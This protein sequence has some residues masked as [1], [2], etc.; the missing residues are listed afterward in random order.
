MKDIKD[1][2]LE[3]ND[4]DKQMAALFEKRMLLCQEIAAYK[5]ANGLNIFDAKREEEVIAK[6]L[7]L[8]QNESVKSY[9]VNFIRSVMNESKKYQSLIF[10]G[11]RVAYSGVPGAFAYIAAQKMYPNSNYV[12]YPDFESA[13]KACENGEA[14]VVVLP[15][16]NSYA[17]DV[18]MVMD[19][20]FQGTLKIN[21][22]C[23]IDVIQNL[24]GVKGASKDTIKTVISHPQALSQSAGFIKKHGY[25]QVEAANTALAALEVK[26]KNDITIGAIASIETAELNGLEVIESHINMSNTNSTRFASLSRISRTPDSDVKM[27]EHFILVYTVKNQAG[28]LA[29]TLNIIGSHGYNMRTVRSRPMKELIWNYFFFVEVEGNINTQDGADVLNE[30]STVCDRLKLAGTYYDFKDK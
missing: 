15:I 12:A 6:N 5:L 13:Y 25:Q 22:M 27:G 9:Y 23:N 16:E 3:I 7:A 19:L 10:N 17:G 4:I 24:L 1:I 18:G 2:R 28:A 30:L 11:L 29:E 26:K 14:D 8:I 21:K 20:I